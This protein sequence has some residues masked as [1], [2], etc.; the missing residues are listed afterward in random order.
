[1]KN[2]TFI[3][4]RLPPEIGRALETAAAMAE[5]SVARYVLNAIIAALP[6]GVLQQPLRPSPPSR[7]TIVPAD[8][9]AA[10][11]RFGGYL[12]RLTGATVQ[13][14]KAV[15]ETGQL[16]EHDALESEIRDLRSAKADLVDLVNR[17]R[18]AERVL[19]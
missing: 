12:G 15:R 16:P 9:I 8:D 3:T 4:Q 13:L 11:A 19:K 1:M 5:V 2:Y 10:I 6:D 17:L 18:A 14:S 7:P